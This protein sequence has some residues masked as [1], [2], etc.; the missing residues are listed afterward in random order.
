VEGDV[1]KIEPPRRCKMT[2][3]ILVVEDE[4]VM[5]EALK[6]WL[7]TSGF[8]V[9]TA[10]DG[11]QALEKITHEDYGVVVLD[12][13]LP[14]KDGV[15]VLK[16]AT[17]QRPHLKA[18]IITAYP[19]VETAVETMK[20]GAVDYLTKPFAPEDLE[21]LIEETIGAPTVKAEAEAEVIVEQ[22]PEIVTIAEEEVPLHLEGGKEL[23]KKGQYAEALREFEAVKRASP[24]DI[25]ARIWVQKAKVALGEPGVAVAEAEEGEAKPKECLWM[26]MG[27][28][29]YRLCTRNYDCLGCEF[30][31]MMQEKMAQ[32][33]P[34]VTEAI[35]KLKA[36]PGSQRMCRYVLK[37]DVSHRFCTRLYQCAGCE[38]AQTM[39]DALEQKQ[40][41]LAVRREALRKKEQA[42]A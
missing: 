4:K 8:E 5:Q 28:V 12:L 11:E 16:E 40:A 21:R 18:I 30:D 20:V 37:G 38:F 42:K 35:E 36:L 33:S 9:D 27:M 39:E 25:E 6:D 17:A 3:P 7:E 13:K 34:E 14:G 22:A 10:G 32:E 29:S 23:F 19:S 1:E 24:A 41:K 26:R 31:Q 2:K 15:Q